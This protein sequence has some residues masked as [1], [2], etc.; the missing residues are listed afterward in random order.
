M[1][2]KIQKRLCFGA[3]P[4]VLYATALPGPEGPDRREKGIS[5]AD[6]KSACKTGNALYNAQ[7]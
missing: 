3:C 1:V 2:E 4:G 7:P 5:G 6:A